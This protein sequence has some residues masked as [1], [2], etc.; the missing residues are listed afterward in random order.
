MSKG[1][2]RRVMVHGG[3]ISNMFLRKIAL[4]KFGEVEII[5]DDL[6]GGTNTSERNKRF[7]KARARRK[8]K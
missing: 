3:H 8:R 2:G 6:L 4:Q 7:K 5:S 1:R